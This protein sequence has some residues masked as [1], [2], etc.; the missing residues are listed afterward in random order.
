[1]KKF[2]IWDP[3]FFLKYSQ[4]HLQFIRKKIKGEKKK[5][6]NQLLLTQMKSP[7]AF[8]NKA[9]KKS[10]FEFLLWITWDLKSEVNTYW[11]R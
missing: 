9:G 6:R 7:P 4:A 10:Y 8:S 2:E 5:K 11:R 3:D 1:M